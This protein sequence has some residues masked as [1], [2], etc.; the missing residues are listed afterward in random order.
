VT[1]VVKFT[2]EGRAVAWHR[3]RWNSENRTVFNDRATEN[4]RALIREAARPAMVGHPLMTGKIMLS[5]AAFF[6]MPKSW[7]S[8]RVRL[9]MQ[10]REPYPSTPDLDNI[11]K[12]AKDSLKS[13]IFQDD[14]LVCCYGLSGK[15]YAWP[16]EPE[17]VDFIL[18]EFEPLLRAKPAGALTA[19]TIDND[20]FA[21]LAAPR[22]PR[23]DTV[24][25][26][27]RKALEGA[28]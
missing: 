9:H 4:W 25:D 1:Q 16:D 3:P 2:V 18:E 6:R 11:F 12:A 8:W 17:R 22:A 13:L 19:P 23:K 5:V 27:M 15:W 7:P 10:R 28:P 14:K 24:I 26:A 21:P 20:L